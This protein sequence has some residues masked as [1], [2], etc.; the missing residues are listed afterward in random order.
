MGNCALSNK[1]RNFGTIIF[2]HFTITMKTN[3]QIDYKSNKSSEKFEVDETFLRISKQI[4]SELRAKALDDVI[5]SFVSEVGK[6]LLSRQ[7]L[8]TVWYSIGKMNRIIDEGNADKMVKL[9]EALQ[10]RGIELIGNEVLSRS[11]VK[12]VLIAGPSSSGKTTFSKKLAIAMERCGLVPKCISFDDYYVDRVLTPLDENGEYDYEHL[13]AVDIDLFQQHF[14]QLLAGEEIELPRYDFMQGKSVKSGKRLRLTPDTVL[15]MEGIHALNPALTGN[16]PD[17]HLFRIYISG[18]TV[19][20][21]D[22]GTYFPT[23]DNRLIRRMVRDAQF[24]G[25]SA[26]DTL[27]RWASVRRG[28]EKWIVPFQENA[29][30]N[31]CTAFQY[32]LSLLKK[33]ALPLLEEVQEGTPEYL[34]AKRLKW[35]LNRFHNIPSDLLPPDSLLREFIGGSIFEY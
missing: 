18:L 5:E 17:E 6:E 7:R 2:L 20:K 9:A 11:D 22:D 21:N 4:K 19:A 24:R 15:I 16:I 34:E 33:Q 28:E 27:A 8:K 14:Q 25:A 29:D 26:Q 3:A 1:C 32:E 30:V 13:H 31:F 12:A 35:V 23:T 10:T